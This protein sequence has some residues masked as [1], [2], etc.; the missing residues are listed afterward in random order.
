MLCDAAPAGSSSATPVTKTNSISKADKLFP[1]PMVLLEYE[2]IAEMCRN[3]T[4]KGEKVRE[5]LPRI[6]QLARQPLCFA[7]ER[8]WDGDPN[9]YYSTYVA[10]RLSPALATIR[11]VWLGDQDY[12]KSLSAEGRGRDAI[13]VLVTNLDIA[14]QESHIQPPDMLSLIAGNGLWQSTWDGI[15]KQLK[16]MG[17]ES[18]A[19]RAALCG[20][21]SKLF[22]SSRVNPVVDAEMRRAAAL[23]REINKLP[24]SKRKGFER[25]RL[26][27]IIQE[28]AL[29]SQQLI[30]QW[31]A[32]VDTV[33]CRQLIKE[34]QNL[35]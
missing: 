26:R 18:L 5:W 35:K 25:H 1:K 8:A 29:K 2:R 10:D 34:L 15:G 24:K 33:A 19:A 21:Q 16:S 6:E 30:K 7:S 3:E 12:A 11:W 4:Y 28:D 17:E 9:E 13:A 22:V 31:D 27:G 23:E 32:E 20:R 14:R